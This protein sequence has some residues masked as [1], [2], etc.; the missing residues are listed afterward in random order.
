MLVLLAG[1]VIATT[2]GRMLAVRPGLV[3]RMVA[4]GVAGSIVLTWPGALSAGGAP[5]GYANGN[6]TLASLGVVAAIAAARDEHDLAIRRG[7]MGLAGLL[8]AFTVATGSVAGI[9]ALTVA[10]GLLGLSA[11]TRWAGFAVVGGLIAVSLTVGVTTAVALGSDLGGLGHRADTRG[12]LWAAAADFVS[13]EPLRGIGHGQ[14]AEQN[15]VSADADLRWAHHGYLQVAAEQGLVGLFL[16]TALAGWVWATLWTA[17][18]PRPVSAS[19]AAVAATV[20]G[21][22]AAVDYVWHLPPVLLVTGALLGAGTAL[23]HGG[24]SGRR[25]RP[26]GGNGTARKT[27]APARRR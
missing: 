15:P 7:W 10:L 6:A 20:V 19:L 24:D 9:I 17:S 21:L 5:L 18:A 12:E 13:E 14:F 16:V 4:V 22:H 25:Q 26:T 8:G 11:V 2:A 23:R 3:P 27:V 1:L